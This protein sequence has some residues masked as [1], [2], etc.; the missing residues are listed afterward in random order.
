MTNEEMTLKASSAVRLAERPDKQRVFLAM[1]ALS[2]P[3]PVPQV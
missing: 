1:P 3:I 2:Y